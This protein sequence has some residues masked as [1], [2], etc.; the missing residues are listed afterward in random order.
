MTILAQI[1]ANTR[2]HPILL[3]EPTFCPRRVR[4]RTIE[5]L[6]ETFECP[7]YYVGVK[8]SLGLYSTGRTTGTVLHVGDQVTEAIG[9]YEGSTLAGVFAKSN[10]A[11]R[12][13]KEKSVF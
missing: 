3:T 12:G 13:N 1:S 4:E 9:I 11:G 6:F 8:S 7:A 2:E 10:Y 5:I